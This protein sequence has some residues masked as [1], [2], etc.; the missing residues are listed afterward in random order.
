MIRALI[1]DDEAPARERLRQL[2]AAVPDLEVVGEAANGELALESISGLKPDVVLLDI[3]MPGASGL[4][5]AACL[6]R[7]RPKIIFCTAF[8]QYAVDA[9]ELNAVDYLLKPVSRVRLAR[10]LERVRAKP[11]LEA[12]AEL[13]RLTEAVHGRCTRLLARCGSRIRIIPQAEVEYISSDG[14]LTFLHTRGQKLVLDPTLNDL[15][16]RLDPERFFRV[17]R[18]AIVSLDAVAEVQPLI[19]GVANV[20]LRTGVVLEVSRRR[21]KDLLE[22][23]QGDRSAQS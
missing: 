7:P 15:E 22:R 12:E 4:E 18:G 10:A 16:E 8:D 13:D 21:V 20:A 9:F 1:V 6:P 19:G 3:Q 14:G 17:S 23:L 5:V 2:L 11:D